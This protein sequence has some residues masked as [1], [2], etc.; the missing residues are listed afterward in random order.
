MEI[1]KIKVLDSHYGIDIRDITEIMQMQ[2]IQFIPG[3]ASYALGSIMPRDTIISVVDMGLVLGYDPVGKDEKNLLVITNFSTPSIAFVVN[4]V[5]GIDQVQE[6]DLI[7]P[8][9][10]LN[11]DKQDV[12]KG[13]VR[14]KDNNLISI[15]NLEEAINLANTREGKE[16]H[17]SN[18]I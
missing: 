6:E 4:D 17:E 8:P 10:I 7:D 3:E 15:L 1:L 13:I 12:L 14:D 9:K 18:T 5:L 16:R 2:P 11:E